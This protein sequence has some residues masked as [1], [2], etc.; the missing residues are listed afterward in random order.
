MSS[1][2]FGLVEGL[3]WVCFS[4]AREL[5]LSIAEISSSVVDAHDVVFRQTAVEFQRKT[6]ARI[7]EAD[8][9]W[10]QLC[11]SR[12]A[13]LAKA[14]S[15][16][17]SV[18]RS[19]ERNSGILDKLCAP[20]TQVSDSLSSAKANAIRQ[21]RDVHAGLGQATNALSAAPLPASA[22]LEVS[23][24]ELGASISGLSSAVTSAAQRVAKAT[25]PEMVKSTRNEIASLASSA[26][27]AA[28]AVDTYAKKAVNAD[29]DYSETAAAL[30]RAIVGGILLQESPYPAK[31]RAA[32]ERI[33][34]PL[35]QL[36][37]AIQRSQEDLASGKLGEA[38]SAARRYESIVERGQAA[39][40]RTTIQIA[41]KQ[42][43]KREKL[44]A[45]KIDVDTS[46]RIVIKVDDPSKPQPTLEK[47]QVLIAEL[48]AGSSE[49]VFS[50]PKRDR[51]RD[52]KKGHSGRS[53][54]T[55]RGR[56]R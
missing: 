32:A 49:I 35:P 27:S 33:T 55:A 23:V 18:A 38:R 44:A 29:R 25:S 9:K 41:K 26:K 43:A 28:R 31:A 15:G 37:T 47:L 7:Q 20:T 50:M 3:G 42:A 10:E 48:D 36:Q 56:V 54:G 16:I 14:R 34:G 52:A 5:G 6:L 45:K 53:G 13:R 24:C 22:E 11:S 30:S 21:I 39:A 40:L 12:E 46:G 4:V 8:R 2:G 1:G 51:T 17:G 19:V